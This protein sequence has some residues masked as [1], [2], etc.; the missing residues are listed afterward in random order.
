MSESRGID[1]KHWRRRKNWPFWQ[2]CWGRAL[3]PTTATACL[4]GRAQGRIGS[5]S[6][7]I[8]IIYLVI[9]WSTSRYNFFIHSVQSSLFQS[10][11]SNVQICISTKCDKVAP[12][13]G[14]RFLLLILLLLPLSEFSDVGPV[15]SVQ[16]FPGM[17]KLTFLAM[18][19]SSH[20]ETCFIDYAPL[21]LYSN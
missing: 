2:C 10:L 21:Q 14:I 3:W 16:P 4:D 13:L 7:P 11:R 5:R 19:L 8:T 12:G 1:Y 17:L 9:I 15:Q 6:S 18:P 20:V